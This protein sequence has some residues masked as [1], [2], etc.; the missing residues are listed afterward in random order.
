MAG[1]NVGC[2]AAAWM[3]RRSIA[4]IECT[5]SGRRPGEVRTVVAVEKEDD[6]ADRA[7]ENCASCAKK[8]SV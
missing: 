8:G 6:D 2:R 4:K 1:R 7:I 5:A 3:T